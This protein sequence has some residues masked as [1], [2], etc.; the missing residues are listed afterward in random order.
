LSGDGSVD[1]DVV[2]RLIG[3]DN[4][5]SCH[6]QEYKSQ[7]S[8]ANKVHVDPLWTLEDLYAHFQEGRTTVQK[9]VALGRIPYVQPTG[10]QKRFVPE[11]IRDWELKG[12]PSAEQYQAL[13]IREGKRR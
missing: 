7:K 1:L 11:V 5:R 9:A 13:K 10:H 2:V 12:C 8:T 6:P 4:Q 3:I